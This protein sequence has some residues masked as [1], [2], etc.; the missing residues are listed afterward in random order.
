MY[1]AHSRTARA[2]RVR[3][4]GQRQYRQQLKQFCECP[5]YLFEYG[6]DEVFVF[7]R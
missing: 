7:S 6:A 5:S 1:S 4:M 3:E 2:N